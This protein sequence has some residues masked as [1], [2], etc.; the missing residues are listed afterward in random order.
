MK[1]VMKK[2]LVFFA[3]VVAVFLVLLFLSSIKKTPLI[4]SDAP[5]Q[6]AAT[7]DACRS[8]H[9]PGGEAPLKSGHPPKE[10]CL[11]CHKRG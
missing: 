1:K 4:P 6:K 2:N 5:H 8:C 9:V 10:Q 3:I 7:A 11:I